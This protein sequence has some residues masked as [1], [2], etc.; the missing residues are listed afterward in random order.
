MPQEIIA[1]LSDE[2]ITKFAYN[3]SFEWYCLNKFWYSPLEQYSCVMVKRFILW[4]S[5]RIGSDWQRNG[6]V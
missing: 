1:A 3:A 4:L 2:N 5:S 6:I